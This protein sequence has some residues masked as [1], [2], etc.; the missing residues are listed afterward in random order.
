MYVIALLLFPMV[1]WVG[2]QCVSVA[3]HGHTHFFTLTHIVKTEKQSSSLKP[4]DLES[5]YLVS[6]ITWWTALT[7]AQSMALGPNMTHLVGHQE[8]GQFPIDIYR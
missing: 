2:L 5:L 1:R 3:F 4:I 7:Y 6:S 8:R